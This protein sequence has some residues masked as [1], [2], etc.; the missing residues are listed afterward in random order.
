[1]GDSFISRATQLL[2]DA[3]ADMLLFIDASSMLICAA[4]G[5]NFKSSVFKNCSEELYP[6]SS[7]VKVS[8]ESVRPGGVCSQ[9]GS[10][11][12]ETTACEKEGKFPQMRS[13]NREAVMLTPLILLSVYK[14]SVR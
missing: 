7:V 8:L 3:I 10:S 13:P 9:L 11:S 12:E 6:I 2:E 5:T 1:M 4:A 14:N